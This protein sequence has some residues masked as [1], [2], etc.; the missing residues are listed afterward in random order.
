MDDKKYIKLI[1][2]TNIAEYSNIKGMIILKPYGYKIWE[3][4]K[5]IL[6][7]LLIKNKYKNVYFPLLIPKNL[8]NIEYKFIKK[9]PKE[10][11]IVKYTKLKMSNKTKTLKIDKKS[12]LNTEYIIRPTSEVVIW[13]TFKKWI[14]TYRDLPILINQWANVVRI[15]MRNKM[16]LRNS[17]FLWQEGHTAHNNKINAILEIN[18]IKKIYKKLIKN[19]LSIPFINGY[20]TKTETFPG[21][22]KTYTFET[23]TKIKGK[24]IQLATIHFLGNNF[25][26]MFNVKFVNKDGKKKY[27]Y[28]TSFGISTRLIGSLIMIHNDNNGLL[29][30][31][32]IAPIQV[33]IIPIINKINKNKIYSYIKQIKK[34]IS[35]KIKLKIDK[36][37]NITPGQKFYKYDN[38]GIP[39]KI[40][41]GNF[42]F[43]NKQILII[44]RDT[45]KKY[46]IKF[47]NN[48][49][50]K[51]LK[52]LNNIQKNIYKLAK[53]NMYNKIK[54]IKTYK[55]LKKN[56]QKKNG[57]F[58]T[59]WSI[60][61]NM[62]NEIKIKKKLKNSIRCII[63][64][65]KKGKCILSGNNTNN[66]VVFGKSY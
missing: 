13:D 20:K 28:G 30:P 66:L 43:L 36:N 37:N 63:K 34:K 49:N 44:R 55:D 23:L 48:I 47:K 33:I 45:F 65:K 7:N 11:A 1:Q 6:N 38:M 18:K 60:K 2:S 4:I 35:N 25:S 24:S 32:L 21:A 12:K 16:L 27:V 52:I 56:I 57:F 8:L 19:Y 3:N 54:Y 29:L 42:E 46:K 5:K 40:L 14:E 62:K 51:L 58:I 61:D 26:R 39:I 41:I 9:I 50:G 22:K 64:N 17:E 59:N 15:E 53:K 10:L 31:P